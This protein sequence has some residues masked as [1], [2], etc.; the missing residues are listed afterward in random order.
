MKPKKLHKSV[1]VE[2]SDTPVEVVDPVANTVELTA[3][4]VLEPDLPSDVVVTPLP[5]VEPI[6][7]EATKVYVVEPAREE[8]VRWIADLWE[9]HAAFFGAGFQQLWEAYM[10]DKAAG[11]NTFHIDV[12]RPAEGFHAYTVQ[13]AG[14]LHRAIAAVVL[15]QGVGRAL[16]SSFKGKMF[17]FVVPTTATDAIEFYNALKCPSQGYVR[18][19]FTGQTCVQ[20]HGIFPGSAKGD[21][22]PKAYEAPKPPAK[23]WR[24]G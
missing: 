5:M 17:R 20:Y 7:V 13:P 12:C 11:G 3:E 9:K 24:K 23:N 2:S 15:R 1:E 8:D 6:P 18:D 16:L 22:I 19:G 21:W 4:Q 10:F 14:I